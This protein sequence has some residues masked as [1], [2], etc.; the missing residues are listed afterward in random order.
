M[1]VPFDPLAYTAL[2]ESIVREMAN[3]ELHKLSELSPFDGAGIY[4][5]YYEGDHPAY[6]PLAKRN[7]EHHGCWAIYI[8]KAEADSKR[9]GIY[10]ASTDGIGEKL[11]RRVMN[12]KRS[13]SQAHNLDLED[14]YVRVLTVVP[15]WVPLAEM[16]AIREHTPVWNSVLDGFGNHNPGRGRAKS[17][18]SRWDTLHPGRDWVENNTVPRDESEGD[19]T[20]RVLDFLKASE[21]KRTIE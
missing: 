11:Y 2:G 1:H 4:A 8:G 3:Q 7:R 18:A 14:F 16:V 20:Q 9:K 13:I 10:D 21:R 17:L 19:L 12:H 5:L 6:V 15:T